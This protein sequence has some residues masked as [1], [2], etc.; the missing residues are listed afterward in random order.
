METRKMCLVHHS[1][2]TSGEMVCKDWKKELCG[3]V[4][5]RGSGLEEHLPWWKQKCLGDETRLLF[6]INF[7]CIIFGAPP[8][9]L[10]KKSKQDTQKGISY[11]IAIYEIRKQTQ[12]ICRDRNEGSGCLRLGHPRPA[13][14]TTYFL[15]EKNVLCINRDNG[16]T[17]V[18]V[19][20]H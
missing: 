12:L 4:G 10:M 13:S 14:D 15:G 18:F 19:K 7:S 6:T 1:I 2:K 16:H 20:T 11:I 3:T 8:F 5:T 9:N 17:G